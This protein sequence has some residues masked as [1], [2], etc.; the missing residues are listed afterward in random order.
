MVVVDQDQV[1]PSLAEWLGRWADGHDVWEHDP[2]IAA[3][4]R[5]DDHY[6]DSDFPD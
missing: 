3:L 5:S 6:D 2:Y 4:V 1:W